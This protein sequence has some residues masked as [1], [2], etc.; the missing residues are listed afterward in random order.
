MSEG[1]SRPP[2]EL[3]KLS[4]PSDGVFL[5]LKPGW[6]MSPQHP[7]TDLET[8]LLEIRNAHDQPIGPQRTPQSRRQDEVARA[9][10]RAAAPRRLRAGHDPHAEEAEFRLA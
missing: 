6:R 9:Q 7:T 3:Q 1:K 2:C 8:H 4:T 5:F 10:R